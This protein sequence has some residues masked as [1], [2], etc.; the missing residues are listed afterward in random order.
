MNDREKVIKEFAH[1]LN[2]A[3]G[4][5]QDFVDLT[6][7][8]G[9]EI[10]SLLKKKEPYKSE[11]THLNRDEYCR[12]G[13]VLDCFDGMDMKADEV[14]HAVCM[15]EWVMGKRSVPLS[16]LLKEHG[17]VEPKWTSIKERYPEKEGFYLV[18]ADHGNYHPWI[19]EMRIFNG[20]KG[21][22]NGA[23]MPCVGAWMPLPEPFKEGR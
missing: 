14:F 7:D 21:F 19:A 2:A 11:E 6:V 20:I 8:D 10:L 4:N 16:Q 9:E 3:K 1:L 13:D 5:Y 23:A 17:A 18:S 15:I 12:V 22:C